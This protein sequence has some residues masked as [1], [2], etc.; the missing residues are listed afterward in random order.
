MGRYTRAVSVFLSAEGTSDRFLYRGRFMASM[1]GM[2]V[3]VGGESL[4]RKWLTWI[5]ALW[6]LSLGVACGGERREGDAGSVVLSAQSLWR[7]F[8]VWGDECVQWKNG[9]VTAAKPGPKGGPPVQKLSLPPVFTAGPPEEWIMPDFDD[10]AWVPTP[11]PIRHVSYRHD[12]AALYLR[13]RFLVSDTKSAGDMRL[14]VTVRGGV[15]VWVNGQEIAQAYLPPGG[16]RMAMMAAL[17]YPPEAYVDETGCLLSTTPKGGGSDA[18]KQRERVLDCTI[19]HKVLRDGVNVVAVA[20]HRA[21]T[22][23]LLYTARSNDKKRPWWSQCGFDGLTLS[24][25]GSGVS[26]EPAEPGKPVFI[27]GNPLVDVWDLDPGEFT[28]ASRPVRIAGTRNGAFSGVALLRAAET[29]RGLRVKATE[30]RGHRGGV[31]PESAVHIRVA[32]PGD[33]A[34]LGA[35]RRRYSGAVYLGVLLE[36][37][38]KEIPIP[39]GGRGVTVPIWLTVSIPRNAQPDTYRGDVTAQY[40]T[41]AAQ[42]P[43]EVYV[44]NWELPNP[45][46]FVSYV[47]LIES[48]ESVALQYGVPLW[49][50]AH[51]QH[52]DRVWSYLGTIG[53][54]S[55]F[56]PLIGQTNLGN[57]HS[58]VQWV[59]KPDG[60]WDHDFSVVERYL[61][62]VV[63]HCGKL[64]VVVLDVW[65]ATHGGGG[66]GKVK[67]QAKNTMPMVFTEWDP[68]RNERKIRQGPD[69]GS[70]ES[71]PFW[72]PVF[73]GMLRRLADR[74]LTAS[75]ALGTAC[76]RV[77]SKQAFDDLEAVAPG[78]PWVIHAHGYT[79]ILNGRKCREA[80][81]VW[82]IGPP[83]LSTEKRF[84]PGWK[85]DIFSPVF[86]RYG[87][88][89]MGHVRPVSPLGVFHALTEAYQAAGYS[90]LGRSGADFWPVVKGRKEAGT[91]ISRVPTWD[92][93]GP[94]TMTHAAYLHPAP[95]GAVATVRFELLR[96]GIQEAEARLFI[97]KALHDKAARARLGEELAQRAQKFLDD[98]IRIILRAKHDTSPMYSV[99]SDA[100]WL[101]YAQTAIQ[102]ARPLYDLAAEIAAKRM[103][104]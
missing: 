16:K 80:A 82:G 36:S 88:G 96:M 22:S 6:V 54:K 102:A 55:V 91:V 98:R 71:V 100:S 4:A 86:P 32:Q 48:P 2:A 1:R 58:M 15:A 81:S 85:R 79:P 33:T 7:M 19:P 70:P 28:E 23:E 75:V 14:V 97:E 35:E 41:G 77:P 95:D 59:R 83:R 104:L 101:S 57:L 93:P 46:A 34:P 21:P 49:S 37:F 50:E 103:A 94:P 47:G 38:P 72:K 29:I 30:L 17:P 20:I 63:K 25:F 53:N 84:Q 26:S 3:R 44:A 69:W 31:I 99:G 27:P 60:T 87:A 74:G 64:P 62:I 68:S 66:F 52:L 45:T 51:F 12:L 42:I 18:V 76:D 92:R 65:T 11:G 5:L 10:S 73:D 39:K 67:E 90:G 61:D 43:L 89:G 8:F 9:D 78:L 40:A 24:S 56:L 13:G